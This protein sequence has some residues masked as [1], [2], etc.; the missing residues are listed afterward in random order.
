[1]TN[2][3]RER[4]QSIGGARSAAFGNALAAQG[5]TDQRAANTRAEQR[6]ERSYT[7][8][9]NQQARDQALQEYLL[10]RDETR[11][12]DQTYQDLLRY[13]MSLGQ[14]GAGVN[15]LG[16]AGSTY[17]QGANTYGNEAASYNDMLA[18]L[19]DYYFRNR[20]GGPSQ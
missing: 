2:I 17:G 13:G 4:A 20:A 3:L 11:Y 15:A 9:L 8:S 1:L 14:G 12:N 7:D 19:A 10:G 18:Q 6:G 16:G 5:Y